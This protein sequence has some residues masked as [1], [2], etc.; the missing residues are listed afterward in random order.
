M[1]RNSHLL[2]EGR[3]LDAILK[4]ERVRLPARGF[5]N[6]SRAA[7]GPDRPADTVAPA[8]VRDQKSVGRAD[9]Q[10]A[11]PLLAHLRGCAMPAGAGLPGLHLLLAAQA[12]TVV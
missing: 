5:A 1:I 10:R 3:F 4:V 7:L 9:A 8:S 2:G 6:R 12:G 11:I